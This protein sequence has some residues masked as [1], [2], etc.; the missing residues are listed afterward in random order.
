VFQYSGGVAALP[1]FA[2][3]RVR[4]QQPV[5]LAQGHIRRFDAT[6]VAV[7]T[8]PWTWTGARESH[9]GFDLRRNFALKA[10]LIV[11]ALV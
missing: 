7:Y 1:G 6:S 9:Q 11:W 5:P 3:R 10:L 2:T 4:F 8:L